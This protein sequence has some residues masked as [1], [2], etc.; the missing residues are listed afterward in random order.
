MQEFENYET[1]KTPPKELFHNAFWELMKEKPIDQI[2]VDELSERAGL[3]RR[4]F[5]RNF[6]SIEDILQYTFRNRINFFISNYMRDKPENF[7]MLVRVCFKHWSLS[8]K[9]FLYILKDNNRLEQYIQ[10][11]LAQ[12][13]DLLL[14]TIPVKD[15]RSRYE[16]Y[17]PYFIVSGLCGILVKWLEDGT[18]IFHRDM[19]HVASCI[20]KSDVLKP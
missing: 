12:T 3:S 20:M 15:E 2:S 14:E 5:Y 6:K 19:Y 8:D 10:C 18:T 17:V 11:F 1:P 9:P 4:T 13:R 7:K 16:A